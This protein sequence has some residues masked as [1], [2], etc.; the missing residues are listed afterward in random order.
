M[1]INTFLAIRNKFAHS[2]SIKSHTSRFNKLLESIF[3]LLLVVEV[4]SLQEVVKMLEE[5]VVGWR[6][7]RWIGKMRQN[8]VAQSVQLLKHWLCDVW[9]ATVVEKNWARSVEQ[10]LLQV[11]QF[12]EHLIDLLSIILR[13]NGFTGIQKVVGNQIISRPPNCDH[14]LFFWCKFGF[15]KCLGASL[16]SYWAGHCWLSYTNHFSSHLTIQLRN[17][18]CCCKE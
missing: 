8:F 2:C 9:S 13:Y 16:F 3:C 10:C 6:E 17:G 14:D 18:S 4:L 5:V 1:T 12:S 15:G 11:L 7:I